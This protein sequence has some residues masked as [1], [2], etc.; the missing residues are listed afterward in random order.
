MFDYLQTKCSGL[1][2]Q[3]SSLQLENQRSKREVERNLLLAEAALRKTGAEG[4]FEE[5]VVEREGG[6]GEGREYRYQRWKSFLIHQPL[7]RPTPPLPVEIYNLIG[8][9][10]LCSCRNHDGGFCARSR[11][12][13][14][15]GAK[16]PHFT[17][18]VRRSMLRKVTFRDPERL[19]FVLS[20]LNPATELGNSSFTLEGF[21]ASSFSNLA[22]SGSIPLTPFAINRLTLVL[23]DLS[24]NSPSSHAYSFPSSSRS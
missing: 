10:D 23:Q 16:D 3:I 15:M 17:S 5:V 9:E 18:M 19:I 21:T 8:E 22:S 7:L 6:S 11:E 14:A 4:Y 20:K 2:Q 1:Q 24:S 12:L 13:L